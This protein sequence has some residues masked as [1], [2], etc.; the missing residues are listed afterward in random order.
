[1]IISYGRQFVFIHIHKT[2]GDSIASA[3]APALSNEDIALMNDFQ[4]WL[5]RASPR[6]RR[7]PGRDLRKHSPASEVREYLTPERWEQFHTFAFVREPVSRAL[8][9]YSYAKRK[10]EERRRILPRN[11]WY[12]TPQGRRTDPLR[13][14]SVRA[15]RETASLSEFLRHPL[16]I[17]AP[18]MQP[19]W[20]S[21]CDES[22]TLLVDFVGRFECLASDFAKVQ[23]RV[24][25]PRT[26]LPWRNA[27]NSRDG[28]RKLTIT[29]EDRALLVHRFRD[30]FALFGYDPDAS[31]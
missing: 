30:D 12:T 11:L 18:A 6:Y 13:W 8:S 4:Q 31:A 26:P 14:P 29:D 2:G 20:K 15:Y 10:A 21:I 7:T 17:A 27:S 5:R 9:V 22:R 28:H 25:I 3:L 16:V 24:G 23:D 19:Q 1:M